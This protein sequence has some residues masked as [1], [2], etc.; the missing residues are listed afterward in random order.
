MKTTQLR[1]P[2]AEGRALS[3]GRVTAV[4][5]TPLRSGRDDSSLAE[6]K[7]F[8]EWPAGLQI[9]PLRCAS[10]GMTKGRAVLSLRAVARNPKQRQTPFFI[11]V[12]GPQAHDSSVR[13]H[14]SFLGLA[15]VFPQNCHPDRSV[16][17]WTDLLF[18]PR[19]VPA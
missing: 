9:P 8:Q 1:N 5:S 6:E 18:L 16:A 3:R 7:H 11:T 14:S 2:P 17:E 19:E 13:R 10:V 12:R 15:F 4:P